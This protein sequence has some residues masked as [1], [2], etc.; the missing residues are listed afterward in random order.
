MHG[1]HHP[2]GT[3]FVYSI[4]ISLNLEERAETLW[5]QGPRKG[6]HFLGVQNATS[7]PAMHTWGCNI[8]GVPLERNVF[9]F[10]SRLGVSDVSKKDG[11]PMDSQI[12][13][14][15]MILFGISVIF[16]FAWHVETLICVSLIQDLLLQLAIC[17]PLDVVPLVLGLW[18][19][20][21]CF[22]CHL[23]RTAR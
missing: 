12:S 6:C 10:N 7:T 3:H 21:Q 11:T 16:V 18:G 5:S 1:D 2:Q 4:S 8:W 17:F 13:P 9:N 15:I 23:V 20:T 19:N 14:K 22:A